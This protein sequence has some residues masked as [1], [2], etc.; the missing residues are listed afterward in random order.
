[1]LYL[2]IF[3]IIKGTCVCVGAI[4]TTHS[5]Y[6]TYM[7]TRGSGISSMSKLQIFRQKCLVLSKTGILESQILLLLTND[8]KSIFSWECDFWPSFGDEKKYLGKRPCTTW[9]YSNVFVKLGNAVDRGYLSIK[10]V[11][12][13]SCP[14]LI[15]IC[16][17]L[18]RRQF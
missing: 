6:N 9:L 10:C 8:R 12:S 17:T 7:N 4:G 15:D 5:V 13:L 14:L 2:K 3:K 11:R 18:W 16:M 1:M